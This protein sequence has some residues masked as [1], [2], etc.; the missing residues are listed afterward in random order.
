MLIQVPARCSQFVCFLLGIVVA[1]AVQAPSV[2]QPCAA[3]ADSTEQRLIRIEK[4]VKALYE[5]AP[6][7]EHESP[8][9]EAP[10]KHPPAFLGGGGP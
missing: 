2:V 9:H 7:I 8:K 10:S 3:Q 6:W 1:S 5:Q 4:M